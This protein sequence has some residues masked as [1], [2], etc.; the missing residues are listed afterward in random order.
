MSVVTKEQILEVFNK[1][2]DIVVPCTEPSMCHIDPNDEIFRNTEPFIPN[3]TC[4]KQ[5]CCHDVIARII[6]NDTFGFNPES[7]Q[8]KLSNENIFKEQSQMR[9][10]YN[11]S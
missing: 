4:V 2:P 6:R 3:S 5:V 1:D 7:L 11:R 9:S 10:I 8:S